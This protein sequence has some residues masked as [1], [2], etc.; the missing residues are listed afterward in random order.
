MSTLETNSIGKYSGNNISIDDALNLKSYTTTQRD[1]LTSVAGDIIYNTTEN[2]PQFYDGTSW[3]SF[4][5]DYFAVEYLIV[6]GGGGGGG[7]NGGGF[8]EG[9]G[10][11]GAGGFL[12][13]YASENSG[14]ESAGLDEVIL[15]SDG[16]TYP[17]TVGAGGSRNFKARGSNG[18]NSNFMTITAIGGG[19]GGSTNYGNDRNGAAGGS[20][21]GGGAVG[22][23]RGSATANQGNLG[24]VGGSGNP[25]YGGGGGGGASSNGG[26]GSSTGGVGGPGQ[27]SLIT[28]TLT[29]YAG[30][31]AGGSYNTTNQSGGIGGG[32]QGGNQGTGGPTAGTANTG[33]GGGGGGRDESY[34][35]NGGSGVVILSYLKEKT[36]SVGA[37]L[38]W[39]GTEGING[40]YKYAVFTAGTGTVTFS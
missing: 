38:T 25:N 12:N 27:D 22:G 20:S 17:I 30:G 23:G 26:S 15:V 8:Y 39:S 19:G 37:G 16:T 33:G 40:D 35:S 31:G 28:G 5:N 32:G 9:G 4:G 24:G 7:G 6:A 14:D 21:G 3:N 10:G 36:I 34:G 13:S 18:T 1:A 29:Y 2:K 11:G